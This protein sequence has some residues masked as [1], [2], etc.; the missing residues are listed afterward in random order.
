MK[1]IDLIDH[2]TREALQGGVDDGFEFGS[3]Q[4]WD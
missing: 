3:V 4:P 2:P 1:I